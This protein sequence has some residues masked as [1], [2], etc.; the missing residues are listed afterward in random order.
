MGKPGRAGSVRR[1]PAAEVEALVTSAVREHFKDS[2]ESAD[3][4]LIRNHVARAEV[5][6][7]QLAIELSD[8]KGRRWPYTWRR[9]IDGRWCLMPIAGLMTICVTK[10]SNQW[11]ATRVV[12]PA[13]TLFD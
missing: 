13:V 5:R 12:S 1:V 7:D 11:R 6:A 3:R 4:D 8:R 10:G 2:T 9:S